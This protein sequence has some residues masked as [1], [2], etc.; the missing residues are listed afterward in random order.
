MEVLRGVSPFVT[1]WLGG[2]TAFNLGRAGSTS[3]SKGRL[4]RALRRVHKHRDVVLLIVGEIDCR[5]HI[6]DQYMRRGQSEPIETLIDETVTRY[7]EV[8]LSLRHRG[9]RVVVHSVPAAA[10]EE[11]I[12]NAEFYAD[13]P[14][15]AQIV[16]AYN[17][18]LSKWCSENGFE[19]LDIYRLVRDETGF[20]RNDLTEDGIHL[21]P[22]ALPLYAQWA[23][24][25]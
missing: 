24:T 16:R 1:T 2:A 8:L 10:H 23:D 19:Y 13:E 3:R 6:Y 21:S 14:T 11:N 17:E 18:R 7:G 25:L 15:R 12:Y 5:I 20:I 22:L 9:Y 4:E